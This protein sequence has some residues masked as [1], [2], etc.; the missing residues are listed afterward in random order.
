MSQLTGAED[1]YSN[2][3]AFLQA[4]TWDG[5]RRI[6]L[7]H[8]ELMSDAGRSTL[9]FMISDRETLAWIYPG[10]DP[11]HRDILVRLHYI[12][13]GRSRQI[14]IRGAF[15]ELVEGSG[16]TGS[17]VSQVGSVA[18]G[19][20]GKA[21]GPLSSFLTAADQDAALAVLREYPELA[22]VATASLVDRL[23]ATARGRGVAATR[24]RLAERRRLLNP[25]KSAETP[26]VKEQRDDLWFVTSLAV[27]GLL[28]VLSAAAVI[29]MRGG[30]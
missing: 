16:T 24:R 28:V 14:G 9:G 18:V 10:V 25:P 17:P 21:I 13:L 27:V 23:I 30:G 29:L 20:E 4:Q 3:V 5:S 26:R 22:E 2:M 11:E 1:M 12:L 7:K 6:V 15:T 19:A 8:P